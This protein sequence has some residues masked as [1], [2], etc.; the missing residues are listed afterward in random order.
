MNDAERT[1]YISFPYPIGFNR[2][3]ELIDTWTMEL[4]VRTEQEFRG[5]RLSNRIRG[6]VSSRSHMHIKAEIERRDDEGTTIQ[7][8]EFDG[9]ARGES[10]ETTRSEPQYEGVDF[11]GETTDERK[12]Q[13]RKDLKGSTQSY[14][15]ALRN[16]GTAGFTNDDG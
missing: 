16:P 1:R 12:R 13:L 2:V 14:F 5:G 10:D 11:M 4:G 3:Q 9:A 15:E 6:K 7:N 8:I